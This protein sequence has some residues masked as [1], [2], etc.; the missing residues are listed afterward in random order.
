[1]LAED[2][3]RM[4]S[5]ATRSGHRDQASRIVQNPHGGGLAKRRNPRIFKVFRP[6]RVAVRH[7]PE[8][9]PVDRHSRKVRQGI[10]RRNYARRDFSTEPFCH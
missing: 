7:A 6:N 4:Q 2:D 9:R 3:N 5:T 10:G 1:M 8:S